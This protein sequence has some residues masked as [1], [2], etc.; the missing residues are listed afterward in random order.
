[1]PTDPAQPAALSLAAGF[2]PAT[3][4]QWG[5]LVSAVLAKSGAAKSGAAAAVDAVFDPT[6]ALAFTTYDGI[7]IAPLYTAVDAP[8]L[9]AAGSPGRPPF[10]RG[11]RRDGSAAA[12]SAA[13]GW[14]VRTRHV[15]PDP[16]RLNRAVLDDLEHGG[17]SLWLGL[18]A[19]GL[20][21]DDLAAA[22]DGVYLD[23]APIVLDAGRDTVPA[24]FA[25]L[26]LAKQRGVDPQQLTGSFGAD[27]IGARA[28]S[29]APA[30]LGVLLTLAEQSTSAPGLRVATIDA[31]V[32]AEAGA[33][34]AQELGIATAVGVAYL[35]AL[36]DGGAG[37]AAG[38]GRDDSRYDVDAALGALEFRWTVNAE[39][40]PSIAKLRAARRVWDRVAELSGASADRPGQLQH[41]VTSP[42]MLTRRDPWVNM[43]RT[44]IACFA[45]AVGGADAITVA[46]FDSAIGVSDDFAR[47]IARNTSAVLHD[48]SSLARVVDPAGGSYFVESLTEELADKAWDVFTSIERAGGALAALDGGVLGDLLRATRER[49]AT[50]VARRRAPITGVSE[51]AFLDE[52]PVVRAPLPASAGE[53]LLPS[54]RHAAD[55]EAL[56][57]RSDAH[58]AATGARPTVV[59][60]ALGPAAAH[61]ARVGFAANLF[62]AGGVASAVA[63]GGAEEIAEAFSAAGTSVACLCGSDAGYADDGEAVAK[64][65]R[66]AGAEHV[67]LA[68]KAEVDGVDG[69]LFTG[70]DALAVLRATFDALAVR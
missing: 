17:T 31:S 35:R 44:T 43:L 61:S 14:D 38:A 28:R 63:V 11:A 42:A 47:R 69:Q 16:A 59:L 32:Y 40:F 29:G 48:E 50:D 6:D 13:I 54:V 52:A 7:R 65:L 36:V 23:L 58:L 26:T 20:A 64:A 66:A 24:V 33:S 1:M 46:P 25:L 9:T 27:P 19:G 18:G 49:R 53:G 37:D 8:P 45:A 57:D 30:D 21:V 62:Q 3:R 56:R 70:C 4:E 2:P 5:A 10:V 12:G 67:W 15:D 22:L 41:A 68:G 39:Q 60:A 55:Y 51:F 34:D